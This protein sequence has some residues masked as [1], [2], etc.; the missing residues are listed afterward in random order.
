MALIRLREIRKSFGEGES[1]IEVLKGVTLEIKRG[2]LVALMG[3]SGSG[4]TTLMNLLGCLDQPTSGDYWLEDVNVFK[5]SHDERSRLRGQRIGF[6]FQSFNLLPRTSAL[7]N[8]LMPMEYND[9]GLSRKQQRTR[10]LKLLDQVGLSHRLGHE[11]SQMS[12]GQQQRVAIARSL[13]NSP[14]LLLAD[15]PTGNLDSATS[16]EI[17]ELFQKLNREE[18]LTILLVT[19]DTG[20]GGHAQ[21]II[22]M[23]DGLIQY[24]AESVAVSTSGISHSG[25][26]ERLHS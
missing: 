16:A 7:D 6:V 20:V 17:L 2:E 10:A 9:E 15:E 8:V 19:H 3:T 25:A 14:S 23:R 22:H 1:K 5:L 4:K 24:P 11:P 18:N 12:G 21:R 13:I 26:L